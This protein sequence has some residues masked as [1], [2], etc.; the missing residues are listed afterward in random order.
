MAHVQFNSNLFG[1]G[2]FF[3]EGGCGEIYHLDGFWYIL[4]EEG[5]GMIGTGG[6]CILS[7]FVFDLAKSGLWTRCRWFF[8]LL[9]V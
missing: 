7:R 8:L 3:R 1:A 4:I 5:E 9:M 6:P 2:L